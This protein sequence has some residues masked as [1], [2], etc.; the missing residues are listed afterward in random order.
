MFRSSRG[1][2][3]LDEET[4]E[5]VCGKIDSF[6]D[7]STFA[8]YYSSFKSFL[9]WCLAEEIAPWNVTTAVLCKYVRYRL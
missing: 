5:F 9:D 6:A 3:D 8:T 4:V 7:S 2:S 1:I